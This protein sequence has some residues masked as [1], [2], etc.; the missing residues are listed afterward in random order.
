MCKFQYGEDINKGFLK[1][2][3]D[4]LIL[5]LLHRRDMYGFELAQIVRVRKYYR[6]TSVGEEGFKQKRLKWEFVRDVID[7]FLD[8]RLDFPGYQLIRI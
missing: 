4:T 8:W 1:G 7:F 5:S 6:L 2:Q 3:I